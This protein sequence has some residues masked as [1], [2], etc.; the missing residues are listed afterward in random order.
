MSK[1]LK[2]FKDDTENF[3]REALL[4]EFFALS[5]SDQEWFLKKA[6]NS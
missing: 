3:K 6:I 2:L 5:F 1:Q 4:K